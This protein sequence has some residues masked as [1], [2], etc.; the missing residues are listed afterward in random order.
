M[1]DKNTLQAALIE[2]QA[3]HQIIR[4]ALNLMTAEQKS[5]WATRNEETGCIGDGTTRANERQAVIERLMKET[6]GEA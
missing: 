5:A 4:N 1:I 2:M 6:R 3:A